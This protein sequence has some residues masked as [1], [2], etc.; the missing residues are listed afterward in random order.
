MAR[1]GVEN[2]SDMDPIERQDFLN[3]RHE[4]DGALVEVSHFQA[5]NAHL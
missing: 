5:M 2:V 3:E 1:K 4:G